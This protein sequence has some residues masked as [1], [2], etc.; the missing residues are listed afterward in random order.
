MLIR[1]LDVETTGLKLPEAGVCE[2]GYCDLV[3]ERQDLTSAPADWWVDRPGWTYVDPG[4]LIPPET[5]AIHHIVDEDVRGAKPWPEAAATIVGPDAMCWGGRTPIAYAAHS[6]KMEAQWITPD[7]TGGVPLICTYKAALRLW[8]DAPRHSNGAL[9]YWLK[10]SGLDRSQAS[11][12]HRAG[13]DAYVT[14]FLLRE[15]LALAPLADLIAWTA[16]PAL[17]IR[18]HLGKWRGA[19]WREVDEGFLDWVSARDFDEDVLFTVQHEL[20]RRRAERAADRVRLTAERAASAPADP[21][22]SIPF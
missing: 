16:E 20:A 17:L 2:I 13:P 19:L 7:I 6:A 9:R 11:L 14:A 5:S 15:L 1:V 3:A 4:H 10:P 12:A 18:C 8:P 22:D 21:D